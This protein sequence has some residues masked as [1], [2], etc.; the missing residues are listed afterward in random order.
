MLLLN[1][2]IKISNLKFWKKTS[3]TA[4]LKNVS[5]LLLTPTESQFPG[6]KGLDL[7]KSPWTIHGKHTRMGEFLTPTSNV[8]M[9][10]RERP[11][12]I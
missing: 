7:S 6:E 8:P 11:E 2:L 9:A 10:D 4:C 5:F 1:N 12:N 3:K